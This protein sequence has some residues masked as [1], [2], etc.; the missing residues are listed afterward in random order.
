MSSRVCLSEFKGSYYFDVRIW[1]QEAAGE[2]GNLKA[3][4]KGLC[5]NVELL[6]DLRHALEKLDQAI[7][8]GGAD[9][10]D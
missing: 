9:G 2:P 6:N 7:E 3:T 1:V 8:E 10:Q 5:L 4:K